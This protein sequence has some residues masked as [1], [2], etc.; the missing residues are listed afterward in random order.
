MKV[1]TIPRRTSW[2]ARPSLAGTRLAWGDDKASKRRFAAFKAL[3][4]IEKPGKPA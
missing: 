3:A 2:A 4:T 1:R